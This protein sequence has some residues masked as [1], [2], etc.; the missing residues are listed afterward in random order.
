MWTSNIDGMFEKV[1]F[2]P[3]LI[4]ACHG[5]LHHL[6]CTKDRRTP[7]GAW[8]GELGLGLLFDQE[9]GGISW[10]IGKI[11]DYY[12]GY[13]WYQLDIDGTHEFEWVN[14]NMG[15]GQNH[16]KLWFSIS[17]EGWTS[18]TTSFF[19]VNIGAPMFGLIADT[20]IIGSRWKMGISHSNG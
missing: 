4:Y 17:S 1:G 6:Q 16:F 13:F 7:L 3:E 19:G 12:N 14:G 11:V 9:P 10:D 5:D 2:P 20:C 18:R 15:I 8:L